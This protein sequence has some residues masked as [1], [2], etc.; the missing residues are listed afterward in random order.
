MGASTG[1]LGTARAQ[2]H[3]RQCFVFLNVHTVNKPEVM[4]SFAPEKI[5]ADGRLKDEKTREYIAELIRS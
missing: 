1:M 3:L 2:Y 4:V 5:D